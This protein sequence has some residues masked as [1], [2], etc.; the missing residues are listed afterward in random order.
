LATEP[1]RART[2]LT[3]DFIFAANSLGADIDVAWLEQDWVLAAA[4]AMASPARLELLLQA[5]DEMA[6]QLDAATH[7]A[8]TAE[9]AQ[10][11]EAAGSSDPATH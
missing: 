1:D 8:Q 11:T 5:L 7:R 2:L 6:D 10:P 3:P 9:A 4:P